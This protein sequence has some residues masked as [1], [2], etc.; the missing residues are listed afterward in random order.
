MDAA[1]EGFG[2]GKGCSNRT[3]PQAQGEPSE[4]EPFQNP[5][6]ALVNTGEGTRG[7]SGV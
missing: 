4:A 1:C 2:F 5:G 6:V 3:F 7:A